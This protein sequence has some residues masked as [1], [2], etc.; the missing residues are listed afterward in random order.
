VAPLVRGKDY[1]YARLD[2]EPDHLRLAWTIKGPA[3]A[4]Y[5]VYRYES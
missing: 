2:I 4:E 1:Y 5:I 3:K